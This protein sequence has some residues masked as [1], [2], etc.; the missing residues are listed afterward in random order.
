MPCSKDTT[1]SKTL[2]SN[3]AQSTHIV[4]SV[5][6]LY[7][8]TSLEYM[9]GE[10]KESIKHCIATSHMFDVCTRKS[11]VTSV[12]AKII[13]DVQKHYIAACIA[14]ADCM[15]RPEAIA[16][17]GTNKSLTANAHYTI[18]TKTLKLWRWL[19]QEGTCIE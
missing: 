6:I 18:T 5:Y 2:A 16:M 1:V 10:Y 8:L 3:V 9:K 14:H 11:N 12:K 7:Q 4:S 19:Y 13:I 15:L 17:N